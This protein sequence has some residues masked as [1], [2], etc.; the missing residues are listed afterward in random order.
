MSIHTDTCEV[1]GT[2]I[3]YRLDG[4]EGRPVVMLSNS[5][6]SN[7]HMWDLQVE[8]LEMAGFRVLRYDSRGHGQSDAPEGPYTIEMLADDAVGLMEVLAVGP[9]HFCGLSKGGMVGQSLGARYP[10]RL[11]SL[12][13]AASAAYMASKTVWEERIQL[14]Q[15]EGMAAVVDATID[16]WFTHHGQ[17]RMAGEVE[18]VRS[19]I[20]TTPVQGFVACARAIMAMDMRE[21]NRSIRTPTQVIVG[22]HDPGTTPDHA[23]EIA[24]AIP[25]ARL[26]IIPDAAHFV[27]VEQPVAFTSALLDHVL[28]ER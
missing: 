15:A 12:T 5:L 1:N 7:L 13:I 26:E 23:R 8:P 19:M 9:V 28:A 24:A 2:R 21:S 3:H 6:A 22:D 10:D 4:D 17:E 14:V 16:R 25:D 18:Q 11:R 27:N 20:L